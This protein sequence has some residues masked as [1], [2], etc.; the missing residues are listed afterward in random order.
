[1]GKNIVLC[2][3]SIGI[4]LLLT[5]CGLRL[6]YEVPP[7]WR[8]PQNRHLESP[9]LG[10]VQVPNSR[11]FSID[12]PVSINSA[13]LRD[14]EIPFEKPDGEI[15]ILALG[16][17]FTFALG[18]RHED[19]WPQQLE[20]LL[21]ERQAPRRFQVINAGVAG[22]NTSQELTY[23]L[24]EGYRWNPD[25]IIVGFYWNDLVGNEEALPPLDT[26]PRTLPGAAVRGE[27]DV[28]WLPAWIRDPLRQSLVLYL[29]VTR[30]QQA[31]QMLDPPRERG[32]SGVQHAIL[33]GDEAFLEPYWLATGTRLL[34]IARW[35]KD[36]GVPVLLLVFPMENLV[37]RSDP[38]LA[39]VGR[40]RRIW[41]PTGMP[42]VDVT[43]AYIEASSRGDNP[44]QPYDLHPDVS[45]MTIAAELAYQALRERDLWVR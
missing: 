18:V 21:N 27:R 1:M 14:D 30:A 6:F 16:D 25:L 9:L 10:W 19:I 15:R 3:V 2:T 7:I 43:P 35:G 44:F 4:A 36:Q 31:W 23:L 8:A 28:H 13:G 5:E 33:T 42:L 39:F 41:E 24:S 34:E 40:L 37:K 11:S 38:G 26:T 17:S 12:V 29:S 20:R 45:G 32:A 22:Y